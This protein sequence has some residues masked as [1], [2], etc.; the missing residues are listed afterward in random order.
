MEGL[1]L[2]SLF[3]GGSRK[4]VHPR[5]GF[6]TEVQECQNEARCVQTSWLK[7]KRGGS[8]CGPD[9]SVGWEKRGERL[10]NLSEKVGGLGLRM[11]PKWKD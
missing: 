5:T 10:G 9:G 8:F 6:G 11:V 3:L 1:T 4:S 2:P 7:M